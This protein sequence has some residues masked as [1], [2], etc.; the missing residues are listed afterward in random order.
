VKIRLNREGKRRHSVS[1]VYCICEHLNQQ[2]GWLRGEDGRNRSK[3]LAKAI[4]EEASPKLL[5]RN[6]A[7]E[8]VNREPKNEEEE[9]LT[10]KGQ[11][12]KRNW[13]KKKRSPSKGPDEQR[14]LDGMLG[15][16]L[17]EQ[18]PGYKTFGWGSPPDTLIC[19]KGSS[20]RFVKKNFQGGES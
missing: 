11:K 10:K 5:N 4:L 3:K 12:M 1:K 14:V 7:S 13:E 18:G 8:S 19:R 16:S 2:K 9:E 15:K 17:G 20:L 6:T